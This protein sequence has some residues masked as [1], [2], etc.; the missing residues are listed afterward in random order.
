MH[1]TVG[2]CDGRLCHAP[3][4]FVRCLFRIHI[5]V[6]STIELDGQD[7]ELLAIG[8]QLEYNHGSIKVPWF[9]QWYTEVWG[10]WVR[11][12]GIDL[13]FDKIMVA[14]VEQAL[15]VGE[16]LQ[17]D[18]LIRVLEKVDQILGELLLGVLYHG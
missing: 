7:L 2:V 12:M 16:S 6:A 15:G 5:G 18:I 4:V 1:L 14:D 9:R 11:L 17:I 8:T 13:E 10:R 3:C